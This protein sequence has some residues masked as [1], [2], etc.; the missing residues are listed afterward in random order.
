MPK[1]P[2]LVF[3]LVAVTTSLWMAA[4]TSAL[5]ADCEALIATF[6]KT[7]DLGQED[8]AQQAVD[9]IATDGSCGA[10]QVVAQ[11]RL[12]AFRLRAAHLLMARGRPATDYERLLASSDSVQV[13]W[14]AAATVGDVRFGERRFA[15]AAMA[16]DRAI[17][18]LKNQSLTPKAPSTFDVNSVLQR[19]AQARILAA[20]PNDNGPA[21]VVK[22][23]RDTRDGTIGGMYSPSVRGLVPQNVP[24]PITF[25]Y[26][27]ATF[28]PIGEDAARELASVLREQHPARVTLVGHTDSRGTAEY[29]QSLSR[30]RAEAVARFLR[31]NGVSATIQALGKGATEPL[32][33]EDTSGLTQDDLYALNRRVEWRRAEGR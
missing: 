20:N 29:N 15:E 1:R 9:E 27:T 32:K 5:G 31:D 16:F 6:N 3:P 30:E 13:L 12:A 11:R 2:S 25:E 23:A 26:G 4:S 7:I 8:S 17:E 33:I 10:Y 19:A 18:I 24:V 28:T 14:Q 22:S 21:Q